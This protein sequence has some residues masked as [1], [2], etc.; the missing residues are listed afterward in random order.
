VK[1]NLRREFHTDAITVTIGD[2]NE[3]GEVYAAQPMTFKIRE[4]GE[5]ILPCLVLEHTDAQ[6]FMDELWNCGLRPSEGSGS[7]GAMAATERH[8]GDMRTIAMAAL[9]AQKVQV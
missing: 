5:I 7:A 2:R 4:P 3:R 6:R 9:R 8:L 1:I